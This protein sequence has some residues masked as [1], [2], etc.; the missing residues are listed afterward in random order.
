MSSWLAG[1]VF[2]A[3]ALMAASL[4][5]AQAAPTRVQNEFM[6]GAAIAAP[7]PTA[8]NR[9]AV[10]AARELQAG[11][12]PNE[13]PD[14]YKRRAETIAISLG[15][16]TP[17]AIKKTGEY[18]RSRAWALAM[19]NGGGS[20]LSAPTNHRAALTAS[21]ARARAVMG[22][23][24]WQSPAPDMLK[25]TIKT[26]QPARADWTAAKTPPLL[27]APAPRKRTVVPVPAAT[28]SSG[29]SL[30]SRVSAGFHVPA[31][32]GQSREKRVR[33]LDSWSAGYTKS[34]EAIT[35]KS[36]GD[37]ASGWFKRKWIET[38]SGF[39]AL[40]ALVNNPPAVKQAANAAGTSIVIGMFPDKFYEAGHPGTWKS[41]II[42][43]LSE[44]IPL[45]L[46]A[47]YSVSKVVADQVSED[48]AGAYHGVKKAYARNSFWNAADATMSVGTLG[49]DLASVT[50]AGALRTGL[51]T[52][53]RAIPRALSGVTH[54][55]AEILTANYRR[56]AVIN[57]EYRAAKMAGAPKAK[58][59]ELR[60]ESQT[61]YDTNAHLQRDISGMR[62]WFANAPAGEPLPPWIMGRLAD[63][64]GVPLQTLPKGVRLVKDTDFLRVVSNGG[65]KPN[66]NKMLTDGSMT[67][68]FA[69]LNK[70]GSAHI[71]SVAERLTSGNILLMTGYADALR[72]DKTMSGIM[73]ELQN[74]KNAARVPQTREVF[75]DVLSQGEYM[76]PEVP[77]ENIKFIRSWVAEINPANTN[78]LI[79]RYSEPFV[80]TEGLDPKVLIDTL[81]TMPHNS[82][83][84][85]AIPHDVEPFISR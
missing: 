83:M 6:T 41:S 20:L 27:M 10:L 76:V 1:R 29:E 24:N 43:N 5:G 66:A 13:T 11:P 31:F 16:T 30:W 12:H 7:A 32:L 3:L 58:L 54:E 61:L 79:F 74:V 59:D 23:V 17:E 48:A 4:A 9:S 40:G 21:N 45:S 33:T 73:Y 55:S 34:A 84:R 81:K 22:G 53:V 67:G 65:V 63:N 52:G 49:L 19:R 44:H 35:E 57:D 80:Y 62:E 82:S 42:R 51:R 70:D 78:Q 85:V 56:I 50:P 38:Q 14:Q 69:H 36:T 25:P 46:R 2:L 47:G 64:M 18:Y 72:A 60:V 28:S 8:A 26:V 68:S 37:S 15:I 77:L 39:Y 71:V 75:N